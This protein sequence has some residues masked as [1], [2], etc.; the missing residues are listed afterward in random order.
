MEYLLVGVFIEYIIN[1]VG[2]VLVL[3]VAMDETES[4]ETASMSIVVGCGSVA[5]EVG[6]EQVHGLEM[7][8]FVDAAKCGDQSELVPVGGFAAPVEMVSHERIISCPGLLDRVRDQYCVVSHTVFLVTRL[9]Q[10]QKSLLITRVHLLHETTLQVLPHRPIQ[11][12][13][14]F[15]HI[16]LFLIL[17]LL[18]M[19]QQLF[20]EKLILLFRNVLPNLEGQKHSFLCLLF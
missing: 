5:G 16:Y 2:D 9:L 1:E 3:G 11:H 14:Q 20:A 13:F 10:I 4:I 8:A 12:S 6:L 17:L 15:H 19:R 7:V 18:D